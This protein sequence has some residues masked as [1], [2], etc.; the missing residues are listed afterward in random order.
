MWSS[1][2]SHQSSDRTLDIAYPRAF[3]VFMFAFL[4]SANADNPLLVAIGL[5]FVEML[6]FFL[7]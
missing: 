7:F 6:T 5:T 3:N 4:I 2:A 1:Y